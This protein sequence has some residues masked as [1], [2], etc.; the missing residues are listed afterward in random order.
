MARPRRRELVAL[1]ALFAAFVLLARFGGAGL[2][3][4]P[5]PDLGS[6]RLGEAPEWSLPTP[7]DEVHRLAD[8]GT[9]SCS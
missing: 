2:T 6:P 5:L 4:P 9:S 1:I 8:T 7:G 3:S